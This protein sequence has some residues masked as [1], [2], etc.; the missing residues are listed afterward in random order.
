MMRPRYAKWRVVT[1]DG[2]VFE[3]FALDAWEA[4]QIVMRR[5]FYRCE[6][7]DVERRG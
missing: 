6:I 4:R 5:C 3:E 7:V 2:R 1:T